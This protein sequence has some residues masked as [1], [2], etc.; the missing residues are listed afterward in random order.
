MT[1]SGP[2]A[3]CLANSSGPGLRIRNGGVLGSAGGI[4]GS[5][6]GLSE[7]TMTSFNAPSTV[8]EEE[9]LVAVGT[10]RAG[11]GAMGRYVDRGAAVGVGDADELGTT[12]LLVW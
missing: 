3:F 6:V 8:R 11:A 2:H 12:V 10:G 5:G 4:Y 9:K 1:L 7:I